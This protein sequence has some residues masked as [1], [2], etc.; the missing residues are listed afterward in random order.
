MVASRF[1][2]AGMMTIPF[3]GV[4]FIPIFFWPAPT[5][6]LGA[7]GYSGA[8]PYGGGEKRLPKRP[9]LHRAQHPLYFVL[10]GGTAIYM[11]RLG[12]QRDE[13]KAGA[14]ERLSAVS[15]PALVFFVLLMNG[16]SIDWVMSLRPQWYSSMLVVE[17]VTEQAVAAL[18]WCIVLPSPVR[19]GD[20]AGSSF[21]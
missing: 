13:Q 21:K 18:A 20:S 1:F 7:P 6:L 5:F 11:R 14:L 3:C 10:I 17:F 15:G 4:L 2:E 9:F 12:R 16:A 8:A 19:G